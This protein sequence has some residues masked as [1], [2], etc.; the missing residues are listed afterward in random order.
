MYCTISQNLPTQ[1]VRGLKFKMEHYYEED[2]HAL[3][4]TQGVVSDIS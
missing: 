1:I 4:L 3:I 2:E